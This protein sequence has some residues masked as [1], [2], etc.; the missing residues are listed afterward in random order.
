M[1]LIKVHEHITLT[2]VNEAGLVLAM[3]TV[4]NIMKRS[5]AI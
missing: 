4:S 2:I 5:Q 3:V 1:A